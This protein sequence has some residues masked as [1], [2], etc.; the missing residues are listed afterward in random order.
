MDK[1]WNVEEME[2]NQ[3]IQILQSFQKLAELKRQATLWAFLEMLSDNP[4][5]KESLEMWKRETRDQRTWRDFVEPSFYMLEA[6]ALRR[7]LNWMPI[8]VFQEIDLSNRGL[9]ERQIVGAIRD[10]INAHGPINRNNANS[11]AKRVIGCIK[12]YNRKVRA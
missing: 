9:L 6:E 10:A 3:L 8:Q 2:D 4:P 1:N 12:T 7:N 11:A 5:L